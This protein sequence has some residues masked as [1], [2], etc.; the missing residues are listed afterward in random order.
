MGL[1]VQFIFLG[2]VLLFDICIYIK[3]FQIEYDD[4]AKASPLKENKVAVAPKPKPAD[5]DEE[6]G[7]EVDI[8]AI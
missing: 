4:R 7:E 5:D 1:A 2:V 3:F 6:G 8:D